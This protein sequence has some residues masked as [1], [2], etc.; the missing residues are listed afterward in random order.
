MQQ[1]VRVIIMHKTN[2]RLGSVRDCAT[3]VQSNATGT[4]DLIVAQWRYRPF[5]VCK[6][7][8]TRERDTWGSGFLFQVVLQ[9]RLQDHRTIVRASCRALRLLALWPLAA[10]ACF[11][12]LV[13]C[14]YYAFAH[15]RAKK[16]ALLTRAAFRL[17]LSATLSFQRTY[18]IVSCV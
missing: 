7:K 5:Q 6:R 4:E 3:R 18:P 10:E 9:D 14:G 11:K 15:R 2:V 12:L 16:C 8:K 17:G 1:Q 13:R